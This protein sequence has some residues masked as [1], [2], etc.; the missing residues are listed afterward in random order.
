MPVTPVF[1]DF[2]ELPPEESIKGFAAALA[3]VN[4]SPAA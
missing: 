1:Q 4:D 3:S 2:Q